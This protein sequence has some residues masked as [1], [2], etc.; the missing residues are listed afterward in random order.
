MRRRHLI[1]AGAATVAGVVTLAG[2]VSEEDDNNPE[3]ESSQPRSETE[4]R[5]EEESE[6]TSVTEQHDEAEEENSSADTTESDTEDGS[7][8]ASSSEETEQLTIDDTTLEQHS[9]CN[10]TTVNFDQEVNTV[11]VI[12]CVRGSNGC[13]EPVLEEAVIDG[14]TLQV[15]VKSEDTSLENRT[16]TSVIAENGYRLTVQLTGGVPDS[17]TVTHDDMDGVEQVLSE[18]R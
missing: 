1:R 9:Q 11:T 15:T 8:T 3:P 17:V 4:Q 18:D 12:G 13:H 16:C 7:G 6:N 5:N 10:T 14:S 2:C